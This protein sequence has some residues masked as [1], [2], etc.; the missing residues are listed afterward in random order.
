MHLDLVDLRLFLSI[1]DA[2]SITRGAD[3]V[4]LALASAS[5]RL[6]NMEAGLG[7]RLLERHHRGVAPTEAGESLAHHARLILRQRAQMQDEL[8]DFAAGARGTIRLYANTAALSEFL[9]P[10]IAP[11]LARHPRL[12]LDLKERTS[13]EIVRA[14]AAGL[15]EAGIVSDAVDPMD[16]QLHPVARD[17]LV[18]IAP[19]AHRL[20][21]SGSVAFARLLGEAFVGLAPGNALQDH[22]VQ[23][24]RDGGGTLRFRVRAKTFEGLCGMVAAGVGIGIVPESVAR[25]LRRRG[26]FA[27]IPLEDAWARRRLCIC[28][29]D[30]AALSPSLRDLL[31][32]LGLP[33]Q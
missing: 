19:P 7:V 24:A 17:H 13:T 32:H 5:E 11:W 27:T 30:R 15:A 26:R 33:A 2:G 14:I 31:I 3:R 6:R 18:A 16:L 1:V 21:R 23:H 12:N 8:Q 10:R 25:R 28:V 4:H 22:I 29:R 9:P 20:S